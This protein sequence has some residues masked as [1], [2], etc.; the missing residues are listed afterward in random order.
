LGWGWRRRWA[1]SSHLGRGRGGGWGYDGQIYGL[2]AEFQ[3]VFASSILML[4]LFYQLLLT[5]SPH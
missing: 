2:M 1:D 5:L 4:F 3:P